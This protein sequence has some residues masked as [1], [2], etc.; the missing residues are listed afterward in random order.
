MSK[1]WIKR[2]WNPVNLRSSRDNAQPLAPHLFSFTDFHKLWFC[3]FLRTENISELKGT[4]AQSQHRSSGSN[5]AQDCCITEWE[6]DS[7]QKHHWQGWADF[8]PFLTQLGKLIDHVGQTNSL[9]VALYM[10]SFCFLTPKHSRIGYII[11]F[12]VVVIEFCFLNLWPSH[13]AVSL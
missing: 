13:S 12:I 8:H 5:T 3:V 1:S 7:L 11:T 2:S 10:F 6:M 9:L 4:W